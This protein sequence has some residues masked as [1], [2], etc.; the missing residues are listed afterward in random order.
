MNHRT[1]RDTDRDTGTLAA[2]LWLAAALMILAYA[3]AG[4]WVS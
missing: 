2:A 3:L 4:L 1:D